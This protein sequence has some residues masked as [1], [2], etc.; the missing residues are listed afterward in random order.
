MLRD[1]LAGYATQPGRYD[2]LLDADGRPRPHWEPFQ[3]ALAE[4]ASARDNG[5]TL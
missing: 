3:R 4:R 5:E 1:L 2:E